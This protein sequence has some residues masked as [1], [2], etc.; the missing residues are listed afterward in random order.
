[1][2]FKRRAFLLA[3][4]FETNLINFFGTIATPLAQ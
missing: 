3:E 4:H 1:M 2:N